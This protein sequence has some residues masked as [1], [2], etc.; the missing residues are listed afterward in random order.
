MKLSSL[1]IALESELL[2]FEFAYEY[3]V[4]S[5]A[6]TSTV[7]TIYS[8]HPHA[9]LVNEW[10]NQLASFLGKQPGF[11]KKVSDRLTAADVRFGSKAAVL[12][13][14]MGCPLYPLKGDI[15]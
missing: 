7:S 15:G 10:W 14:A 1:S 9:L 12:G 8:S 11:S 4:V 6:I 13:N 5:I 3:G 2:S